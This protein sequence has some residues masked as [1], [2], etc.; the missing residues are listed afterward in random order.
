MLELNPWKTVTKLR[1]ELGLSQIDF[2]KKVGA[3]RNTIYGLE[4]G[5]LE[6]SRRVAIRISQ[7]TGVNAN[8]LLLNDANAPITDWGG[9][10][11]SREKDL[12]NA[13]RLKQ[14]PEE[15]P[16]VLAWQLE[17]CLPLLT[18]YLLTREVI[19]HAPNSGEAASRWRKV[20]KKALDEF[21]E[22]YGPD[23]GKLKDL[24]QR[25]RLG[26][27]GLNTI[28]DDIDAVIDLE[29]HWRDPRAIKTETLGDILIHAGMA[30]NMLEALGMFESGDPDLFLADA[31]KALKKQ[32]DF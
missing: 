2:A 23:S 27:K 24:I 7:K 18:Q 14:F 22:S 12:P 6:L 3:H 1:E 4:K 8:W 30:N 17:T 32:G 25:F 9:R 15:R 10:P 5:S 31:V 19:E 21:V 13:E 16:L 20:Y 26:G 28:R 11:W 29:A